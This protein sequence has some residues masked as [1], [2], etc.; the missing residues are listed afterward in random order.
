M[1]K[2]KRYVEYDDEI[3]EESYGGRIDYRNDGMRHID[4]EETHYLDKGDKLIIRK[5]KQITKHKFE[6]G[7]KVGNGLYGK[8]T[9]IKI[10]GRC[11]LSIPFHT[12]YKEAYEMYKECPVDKLKQQGKEFKI[13]TLWN[14]K[15]LC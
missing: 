3:I 6:A 11:G 4:E 1:K 7:I 10:C 12:T 2:Q 13:H 9:K 5:K 14:K 8:T 15:Q